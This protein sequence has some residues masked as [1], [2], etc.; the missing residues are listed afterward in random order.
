M[1]IIL[2]HFEMLKVRYIDQSFTQ[3]Q[4]HQDLAPPDLPHQGTLLP[5]SPAEEPSSA[6]N[7]RRAA[8]RRPVGYQPP[9]RRTAQP[10]N[11]PR[12]SRPHATTRC[13]IDED[14]SD[15][16][17]Q[18][19]RVGINNACVKLDKYYNR[20]DRSSAY[21]GSVRMHPALN[22]AWFVENFEEVDQLQWLETAE[23]RLMVHYDRSY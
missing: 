11:P 5:Q 3:T 15:A 9:S 8:D 2:H 7:P 23:E 22:A 14:V 10:Q 18:H 13:H 16:G 1:E 19:F 12:G 6:Q 20:M 21:F 4:C 17:R